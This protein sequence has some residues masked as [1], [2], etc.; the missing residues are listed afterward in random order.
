ML[1]QYTEKLYIPAAAALRARVS[2]GGKLG[3]EIEEWREHIKR[4]WFNIHFGNMDVK[5]K[6]EN[7][8][9]R[10]QIYLDDLESAN[11]TVELYAEPYNDESRP[12]CWQM[13]RKGKLAGAVNG[14][15]Y[16]VT[17]PARRR[18]SDYTPRVRPW[19]PDVA[20][21]LEDAHI[22]WMR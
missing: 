5:Q 20:T 6:G 11:V 4:H 16:E 18:S 10:V 7:L 21:P 19:H 14:F 3:M 8:I 2:N 15:V 1:R 12:E 17:V 22:L 13:E 9:F